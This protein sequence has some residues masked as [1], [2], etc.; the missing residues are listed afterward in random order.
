MELT[1]G[2]EDN[3]AAPMYAVEAT[4]GVGEKPGKSGKP[5]IRINQENSRL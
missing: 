1:N 3:M 2:N 5:K 4:I